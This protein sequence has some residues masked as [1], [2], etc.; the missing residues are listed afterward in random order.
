M[1]CHFQVTAQTLLFPLAGPGPSTLLQL[2]TAQP[3]VL[4]AQGCVRQ[5]VFV[6]QADLTLPVRAGPRSS[7]FFDPYFKSGS[8][9]GIVIIFLSL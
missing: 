3:S 4:G 1:S 8:R 5:G 9:L 2:R 7:F 6:T